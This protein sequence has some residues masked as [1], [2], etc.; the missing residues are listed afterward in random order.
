M[1]EFFLKTATDIFQHDSIKTLNKAL[2]IEK[3]MDT[4]INSVY[5]TFERL[6]Y[7]S[8]FHQ[9]NSSRSVTAIKDTHYFTTFLA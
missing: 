5:I 7:D 3:Y 2:L 4:P 8:R 9:G 6:N 1:N